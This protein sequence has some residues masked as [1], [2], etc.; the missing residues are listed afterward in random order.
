MKTRNMVL[1]AFFA[2]VMAMCAWLSVP[3]QVAF[4]LQTFGVLLTL[5]LLGGK[6]GCVSILL[7]LLLGCVG[8][9]VFSGFQGGI[10][11]LLGVS[12][13]YLWGFLVCALVY[14]LVTALLP[15]RLF[16]GMLSGLAACYVCGTA[17][18]L[19]AYAGGR[20]FGAVVLTFCLPYLLPDCLKLLLAWLL[21]LK[22]KAVCVRL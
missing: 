21:T 3:G 1:C 19:I 15:G 4:T 18:V 20:S 9:P 10:G 22:L 8:L 17:W 16:L 7:Y 13:G 12:G 6:R 5:G 2:S 11:V 14:W